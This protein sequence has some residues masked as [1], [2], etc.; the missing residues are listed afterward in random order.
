MK[1]K[2]PLPLNQFQRLNREEITY[3]FFQAFLE[4]R[5]GKLNT[6]DEYNFEIN[7][8]ENLERLVE[9]V[10]SGRYKPSRGIA[11]VVH[12]HVRREIFAAPFR[13]RI[14]HHFIYAE[15]ESWWDRRFINNSFSCRV[16]KGTLY[17]I[18]RLEKD[19]RS[20]TENYTKRAMVFKF[21]IE[22]YFMS[23]PRDGLFRR[24]LWGL[25]QQFPN[26][27]PKYQLLK[28]L[29][30]EIIFDDPVKGVRYRPP[31]SAWKLLPTSK[32]LALQPEGRGIVIG[33]LSSQLLSNIYLDQLD[34]FITMQ[35]GYKH[36][37]RYVDDF[38]IV[39]PY[40]KKQQVLADT[41]AIS[42]ELTRLGLTLHPRKFFAQEAT[43]GIPF[44]GMVLYPHHRVMNRRYKNNFYRAAIKYREGKVGLDT[45][46][47]YVGGA[48]Y[49]SSRHLCEK[50]LAEA[51]LA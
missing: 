37:G 42:A 48:K 18:E 35:L 27:G 51:G 2:Y 44:L 33:N 43:H 17:G 50:M 10:L 11:F 45:L 41:K 26:G 19:I 8:R 49:A 23:L 40:E 9:E 38:Y 30:A 47:S 13:D 5:K 16:G 31:R 39:V 4:A 46:E 25:K 24:A 28:Y 3:K 21:D 6:E 7:W 15:V 34:R 14:V 12:D 22:G 36:Y 29:W 32:I 20:V 1:R